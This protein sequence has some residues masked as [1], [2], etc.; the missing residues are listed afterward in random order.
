MDAWEATEVSGAG[1]V[2]A[3]EWT[4]GDELWLVDRQRWPGMCP[5]TW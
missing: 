1:G 5:A 2:V 4:P 3:A